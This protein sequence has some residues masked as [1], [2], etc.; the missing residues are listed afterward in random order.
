MSMVDIVDIA[1]KTSWVKL[2]EYWSKFEMSTDIMRPDFW[3]WSKCPFLME[4]DREILVNS[5]HRRNIMQTD[6]MTQLELV[7]SLYH[8]KEW[9][10]DEY[11]DEYSDTSDGE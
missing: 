2:D 5:L 11:Y 9:M 1:P 6:G 4:C 3:E 10:L 7:G 8:D